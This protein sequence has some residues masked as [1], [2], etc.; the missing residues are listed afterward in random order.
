MTQLLNSIGNMTFGK[1]IDQITL[2]KNIQRAC[3]LIAETHDGV[4]LLEGGADVHPAYYGQAV[5]YAFVS[6]TSKRRDQREH[7]LIDTA[8]QY[9][10]PIIGLCRG[11]QL[12]AVHMGGTLYQDIYEEAHTEHR[13][14]HMVYAH[15]VF[16]NFCGSMYDVNSYHHQAVHRKPK[17]AVEIATAFDG[18]NEGLFYPLVNAITVQWHPEFINDYELLNWMLVTLGMPPTRV[19]KHDRAFRY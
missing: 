10:R 16:S 4:L 13:E 17:Q 14:Y 8:L 6:E 5:H 12:F 2:P 7:T 1:E 15:D 11:H 9:K 18:L 3:D 19:I